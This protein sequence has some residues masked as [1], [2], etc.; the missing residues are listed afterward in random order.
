MPSCDI[1]FQ[2]STN[3]AINQQFS[4][5]EIKSA[6]KRLKNNKASGTDSIINKFFK[7]CHTDCLQ[8][9][10]DF[11]NIIGHGAEVTRSPRSLKDRV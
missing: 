2:I 5:M 7:H 6:I 1:S 8:I 11:F 10:A 9:N 3:D 4:M